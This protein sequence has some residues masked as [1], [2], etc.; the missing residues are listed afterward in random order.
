[1]INSDVN[2]SLNI[3]CKYLNVECDEIIAPA[4]R[5]LVMNPVKIN[6]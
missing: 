3:L 4:S 5:E 6:F 1:M 2:G